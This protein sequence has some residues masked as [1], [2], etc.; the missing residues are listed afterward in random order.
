MAV[1][2]AEAARQVGTSDTA[3]EPVGADA[4]QRAELDSVAP[5]GDDG[6]LEL[7]ELAT[8][9]AMWSGDMFTG[10]NPECDSK[11]DGGN[12]D[13][14]SRSIDEQDDL[15]NLLGSLLVSADPAA[16]T[17][18]S[19]CRCHPAG[20]APIRTVTVSTIAGPDRSRQ[21]KIPRFHSSREA[22]ARRSSALQVAEQVAC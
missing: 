4:T 8:L 3:P 5:S 1:L 6:P 20:K 18:C 15:Q 19:P 13:L 21:S 10:T 22:L 11:G 2:S 12:T 16:R 14:K 7:A 9:K 17:S